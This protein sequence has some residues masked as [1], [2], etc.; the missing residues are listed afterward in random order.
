MD[1]TIR[2]KK[3]REIAKA[4]ESTIACSQFAGFLQDPAGNG[5]PGEAVKAMPD[6]TRELLKK[7]KPKHFANYPPK[8]PDHDGR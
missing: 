6:E 1:Y 8:Y 3:D 2:S 7:A 4:V 5:T